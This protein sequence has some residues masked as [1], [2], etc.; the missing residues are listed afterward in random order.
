MKLI[1]LVEKIVDMILT[2]KKNTA[3]TRDCYSL[4]KMIFDLS[5]TELPAFLLN[6]PN[7]PSISIPVQTCQNA[8]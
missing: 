3:L 2:K 7:S 6:E 1:H 5:G 4:L 8:R